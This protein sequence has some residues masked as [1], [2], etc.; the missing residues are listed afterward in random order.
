MDATATPFPR[1]GLS[2][3][4]RA[5]PTPAAPRPSPE[6]AAAA[7][8]TLIA[9]AGDDPNREGLRDTP[10]RV[11]NSYEE[12]FRGYRE[13]PMDVLDRTFSEIGTY[14]DLVLIRDI[15]FYSHCEHHIAPFVGKAHIGYVPVEKVVGLSQIERL[16]DVYARRHQ[17]Q[18][19]LPSKLGT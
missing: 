5:A 15:P 13:C 3:H 4:V 7:V 14:D 19:H 10:R 2:E 6:E 16:I 18:A 17:T 11:V 9:F 8:R 1:T 12:L